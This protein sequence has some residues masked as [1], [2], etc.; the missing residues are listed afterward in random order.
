MTA[1]STFT[2]QV[3]EA[4][5]EGAQG[6]SREQAAIQAVADFVKSRI[7]REV[8]GDLQWSKS[9]Q[10][11]YLESKVRLAGYTMTSNFATVKTGVQ[12]RITVDA[13][14]AA[15]AT[16]IDLWIQQGMD[17]LNGIGTIWGAA[18]IEGVVDLQRYIDNYRIRHVTY[19]T[20]ADVTG[21]GNASTA[22]MPAGARPYRM[23]YELYYPA[24]AEG[25]A[26]V[27]NQYVLS[28]NKVYMVVTGGT[29]GVGQLGGGLTSVDPEATQTL[30]GLVF[31]YQQYPLKF[32]RDMT[33][34]PWKEREALTNSAAVPTDL[35][36]ASYT[37]NDF[38]ALRA[39]DYMY[40]LE[41]RGREF[42]AWPRLLTYWRIQVEWDGIKTVFSGADDEQ[43][44][45]A[46]ARAVAFYI[47][48]IVS[49]FV[50]D[51]SA[52]N[53]FL[54]LYAAERRKL[55]IQQEEKKTM[56]L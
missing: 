31:Q 44:G 48:S 9:Y 12:A 10:D 5:N 50:G 1:W 39:T 51:D 27:A 19:F 15:I 29:I 35:A 45:V 32:S 22:S 14:R 36:V 11:R 30:D 41:P 2:N 4:Y 56:V 47:R 43:F 25:V 8:D 40:A 55:W 28:N 53:R 42:V 24:L 33:A 6:G 49:R 16:V 54:Q 23:V 18:L 26:Y 20:P 34:V 7:L 46:E 13:S 37:P 3:F 17:D 52:A 38:L 21:L